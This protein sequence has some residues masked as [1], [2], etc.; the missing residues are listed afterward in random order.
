ML[1][2]IFESAVVA[3]GLK[4]GVYG[5]TDNNGSDDINI[6][7]SEKR[8]DAV[9]NYLLGKGLGVNRIETRGYGSSKPVADNSTAAGRGRNRRVEIV[10]GQ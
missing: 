4:L 7:L 8:A 9:K 2:E 1:D 3:E 5:H 10:L 6:P